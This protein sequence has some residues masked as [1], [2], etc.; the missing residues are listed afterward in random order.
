MLMTV[1]F[2]QYNWLKCDS[3]FGQQLNAD[4][5]VV[6]VS[7]VNGCEGTTG[8]E[9]CGESVRPDVLHWNDIIIPS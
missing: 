4:P 7:E 9:S 2:N 3:L 6:A 8:A 1:Y 5:N